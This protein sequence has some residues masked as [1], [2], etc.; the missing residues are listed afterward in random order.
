M[1]EKV[2]TTDPPQIDEDDFE[3]YLATDD[4]FV[5]YFNTFLG[6]PSFPE[7]LRFNPESGGF[8]VLTSAKHDIAE[9]IK[10]AA[11]VHNTPRPQTAASRFYG[12]EDEDNDED[13]KTSFS[14]KCLDK[15]QGIQWIKEERLPSFLQSE[16]YM[17]YR[18]AKLLSQV[19]TS[20]GGMK[21]TIDPDF[22]PWYKPV[23]TPE[24]PPPVDET[25]IMIQRMFVT[26][27]ST[28]SSQ[29]KEWFTMAKEAQEESTTITQ[30]RPLSSTTIT[31]G[32][33]ARPSSSSRPTSIQSARLDIGED[34]SRFL[35]SGMWTGGYTDRS[36]GSTRKTK[37]AKSAVTF[38]KEDMSESDS[39]H[40]TKP[41]TSVKK[42]DFSKYPEIIPQTPPTVPIHI[43]DTACMLSDTTS[44]TGKV[45]KVAHI[46]PEQSDEESDQGMGSSE[47]ESS[48]EDLTENYS[49]DYGLELRTLEDYSSVFVAL[50]LKKALMTLNKNITEDTLDDMQVFEDIIPKPKDWILGL[51]CSKRPVPVS[52]LD[53]KL[54]AEAIIAQERRVLEETGQMSR[55]SMKSSK[56]F[57]SEKSRGDILDLLEI[58][59]KKITFDET[60]AVDTE[61]KDLSSNSSETDEHDSVFSEKSDELDLQYRKKIHQ[62]DFTDVKGFNKF[63]EFI[64]GTMGDSIMQLWMDIDKTRFALSLKK[65]SIFLAKLRQKY[66]NVSSLN[67]ISKEM[68]KKWELENA[69]CWTNKNLQNVQR[70]I[71]ESLLL[72][73][74]PRF[75]IHSMVQPFTTIPPPTPTIKLQGRL[76]RPMSSQ[77]YPTPK[78][79]IIHPLRPKSCLPRIKTK[80]GSTKLVNKEEEEKPKKPQYHEM[81]MYQKLTYHPQYQHQMYH[82]LKFK[83]YETKTKEP[84]SLFPP[85]KES[86]FRPSSRYLNKMQSQA[87][88]PGSAEPLTMG[89]LAIFERKGRIKS[90]QQLSHSTPFPQSMKQ[91]SFD[92]HSLMSQQTSLSSASRTTIRGSEPMESMLQ[93]LYHD[94]RAGWFFTRYCEQS[95]NKDWSNA[96]HFWFDTQEFHNLFYTNSLDPF[97]V[98]RKAQILYSTYIVVSAP[99][100]IGLPKVI[101]QKISKNLEPAF[102]ELFDAAE[103][104]VL[105][106]LII[107]WNEMLGND[108]ERYKKVE[109]IEQERNLQVASKYLSFLQRKG[110]IK[111][112]RVA[113]ATDTLG[114]EKYEGDLWAKVPEEYRTFSFDELV[115][116]RL[117]L[118]HFRKFLE[119][120]YAK[121]D[122]LC[123]L[124]IESF[125]RVPHQASDKRD[126]KAREIKTKYLH[127]KYFFG[128]SS[129]AN[130]EQQNK[131]VEISG[132]WGMT[133]RERPPNE[134]I[135]EAQKYVRNRLEKRWLPR[136]LA[137]PGFEERQRPPSQMSDVAEDI[138]LQKKKKK[139]EPWK[140]LDNKW[141]TSS[142]ELVEFRHAL[143]NPVT[144]SQFRRY[145]AVK[146]DLLENDVLFWLEVQKYKDFCHAHNDQSAIDA[147][148]FA[149]IHCFL[150]SQ[151][152]PQVQI[153]IPNEMA[154][155]IIE[156][157]KELGPYVF[158]EAQLT[159]FRVLFPHWSGFCE[160]RKNRTDEKLT[161]T[162]ERQR[163]RKMEKVRRQLIQQQNEQIARE[164]A[165]AAKE[166]ETNVG[167]TDSLAEILSSVGSEVSGSIAILPP[168]TP[169]NQIRWSYGKYVEALD[170]ER[171]LLLMENEVK[172]RIP[173]EQLPEVDD[174]VSSADSDSMIS[175]EGSV[176]AGSSV[177]S[178]A[179][180]GS[181]SSVTG[182]KRK[183]KKKNKDKIIYSTIPEHPV[184]VS[185]ND[186]AVQP[187]D[188]PK[189][190][191]KKSTDKSARKKSAEPKQKATPTNGKEKET[192]KKPVIVID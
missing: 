180:N 118:E 25:E 61:S 135:I 16:L 153:D 44:T 134:M 136:F 154:E 145:V 183:R 170:K 79:Q 73:W 190:E 128:P 96:I 75:L 9:K 111:E 99:E 26:L 30:S 47:C 67:H 116:N 39:T 68:L 175:D 181:M 110:V 114:E 51:R 144:S 188:V 125:K 159:V 167:T 138:V 119:E 149:I 86:T 52:K 115:R 15:E 162:L 10:E 127:K 179:Q 84:K 174:D 130:K 63:K 108:Q 176:D 11:R 81:G 19:E 17:E 58:P 98:Q 103:E 90:A 132:G 2:I 59:K 184:P 166:A 12:K 72:Y 65:V 78:T 140:L 131:V 100:Q 143:A 152:P 104:H 123:W 41:S 142:R 102:D 45:G 147:K 49:D 69:S 89:T 77:S 141:Q 124:D 150:D 139:G 186:I 94:T 126:E 53:E 34:S 80:K 137:T 57:K 23:I 48:I 24:S 56:S 22:R 60:V 151:I 109:M 8:E 187:T 117:E 95:G 3:D 88:R 4:L 66:L 178:S 168:S 146:G 13:I 155:R 7:P 158:R 157:R 18:L 165:K 161:T 93:A 32:V 129:P 43:E 101:R 160:F 62:Y 38:E 106:L 28:P 5:D 76:L 29:T 42:L 97:I 27:G 163:A 85:A 120:N 122:L 192:E 182:E 177:T 133:L 6:L 189:V 82:M 64:R 74:G 148:I 172:G 31:T 156:K 91:P 92:R 70:S 113:M 1:P 107:P 164:L 50:S 112:K 105:K 171:H 46:E 191:S 55:K 36:Y 121:T 169:G 33:W 14:V 87:K 35:D 173:A 40:A 83:Q 54:F 185:G 37:S 21:L 71:V 20:P